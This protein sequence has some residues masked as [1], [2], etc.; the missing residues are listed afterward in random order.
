MQ[1][2]EGGVEREGWSL[3]IDI[4]IVGASLYMYHLHVLKSLHE[5]LLTNIGKFGA[6]SYGVKSVANSSAANV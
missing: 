1:G 2:T 5:A 4:V 6:L 3:K